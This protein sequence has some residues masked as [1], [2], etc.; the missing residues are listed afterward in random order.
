MINYISI[1]IIILR[2]NRLPHS[3]V[4]YPE[5]LNTQLENILN[6]RRTLPLNFIGRPEST[7]SAVVL[8]LIL[9][10]C[11]ANSIPF[12]KYFE[13]FVFNGALSNQPDEHIETILNVLLL[14]LLDDSNCLLSSE[15]P[16]EYEF[17]DA[18]LD[19]VQY[20]SVAQKSIICQQLKANE[21]FKVELFRMSQNKRFYPTISMK[22]LTVLSSLGV[23]RTSVEALQELLQM[24]E[25]QPDDYRNCV[26][27]LIGAHLKVPVVG[28]EG[29]DEL[30]N[31]VLMCLRDAADPDSLDKL[32]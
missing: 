17:T 3:Q 10:I 24:C 27:K 1:N 4:Q 2:I 8:K 15:L 9:E 28:I 11:T 20:V 32:R 19:L 23:S 30:V 13:Q 26:I 14:I 16:D 29:S 25:N 18:E 21:Q 31:S 6:D 22:L 5:T 7:R 12:S